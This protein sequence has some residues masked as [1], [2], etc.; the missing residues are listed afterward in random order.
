METWV[1]LRSSATRA[2]G[3]LLDGGGVVEYRL[4]LDSDCRSGVE[5]QRARFS[6]LYDVEVPGQEKS[7]GRVYPK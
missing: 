7:G 6:I 1:C 5:R 3:T 2:R 4:M